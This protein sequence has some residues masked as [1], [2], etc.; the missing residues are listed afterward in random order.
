MARYDRSKDVAVYERTIDGDSEGKS[1]KVA[2]MSYNGGEMKLQIGPRTY[3]KRDGSTGYAKAGR[4]TMAE[5]K[6]IGA[7]MPEIE[8]IMGESLS[9]VTRG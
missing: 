2:V 1:L 4:M 3:L 8:G 5:V 7:M 9:T 6:A